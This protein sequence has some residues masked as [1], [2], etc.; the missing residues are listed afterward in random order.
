MQRAGVY[1]G[2]CT[3]KQYVHTLHNCVI[4][5]D[6][7]PYQDKDP[8]IMDECP[9][10]YFSGNQPSLLRDVRSKPCKSLHLRIAQRGLHFSVYKNMEKSFNIVN[11]ALSDLK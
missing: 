5:L 11:V 7:Y 3:G 1:Y 2:E 6:C 10:V 8:F 9:D 4:Y